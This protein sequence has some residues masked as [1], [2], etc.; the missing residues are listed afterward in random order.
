MGFDFRYAYIEP[1]HGVRENTEIDVFYDVFGI[2]R[3]MGL[4]TDMDSGKP[5]YM[6]YLGFRLHKIRLL[7]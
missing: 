2:C 3:H 1:L 6:L 5:S 4:E 7:S